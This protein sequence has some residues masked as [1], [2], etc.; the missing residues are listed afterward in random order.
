MTDD[1]SRRI[2]F[3]LEANVRAGLGIGKLIR[4]DPVI[5][6]PTD[7]TGLFSAPTTQARRLEAA[8]ALLGRGAKNKTKRFQWNSPR[9]VT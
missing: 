4:R 6:T 5:R 2:A 7:F 8:L 3:I 9:A 1:G